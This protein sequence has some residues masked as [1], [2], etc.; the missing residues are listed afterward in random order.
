M[1]R[2]GK[3]RKQKEKHQ[4]QRYHQ[5][6]DEQGRVSGQSHPV[7]AEHSRKRTQEAHE[8]TEKF[9][10]LGEVFQTLLKRQ[11]NE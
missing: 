11:G 6:V 5:H 2:K 4:L 8:R 10:T 3:K 9:N 1:A 7:E